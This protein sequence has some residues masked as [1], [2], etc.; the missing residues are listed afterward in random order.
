MDV[1]SIRFAP[2]P[3]RASFTL[4]SR[5]HVNV[6]YL[7]PSCVKL[8][9]SQTV[10]V[11]QAI[12]AY[13]SCLCHIQCGSFESFMRMRHAYVTYSAR[14]SSHSRVCNVEM[15]RAHMFKK[16]VMKV[17]SIKYT[18]V[19]FYGDVRASSECVSC[20]ACGRAYF[21]RVRGELHAYHKLRTRSQH[22]LR[23]PAH[24][25]HARVKK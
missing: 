7:S 25:S 9:M 23:T 19:T 5:D 14:L 4:V 3:P 16:Q 17:S 6:R 1:A 24:S 20:L 18:S 2:H 11:I 8:C 21:P 15:R 13:A 12:H 22:A 10:R